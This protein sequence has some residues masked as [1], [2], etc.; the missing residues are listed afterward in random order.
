MINKTLLPLSWLYGMGVWVRNKLFDWEILPVEKFDVPV[1]SIGNLA[2]GGTGKT[3]H[4]EYLIRMLSPK[5]GVAVLSRGYKRKTR[6]FVLADG[7]AD[8]RSI[9]DEPYQIYRKFPEIIVAVDSN[10]RRGIRNL[11]YATKSPKPD[12]ILLDDA[13]QH[14]Y[15]KPSFSI[16]LSDSRRPFY[17]DCLLPAGRLREPAKNVKRADLI[18]F[19]KYNNKLRITNYELRNYQFPIINSQLAYRSLLPVFPKEN[20]TQKESMER[21][22]EASYSVLLLAGLASP[23]DLIRYIEKYTSGLQTMIYPD[24]HDFSRKDILKITE[25]FNRIQNTNKLIIT[26][27]KDAV[28]LI[29]NPHIPEEIKDLIYYIPIAVVFEPEQE[30]LFAQIIEN[31][32]KH[33]I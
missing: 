32:V 5:Y 4:T 26:S 19:T 22:R 23:E 33:F 31:H 16:L 7:H 13:F 3:P 10:R 15:V 20:S 12:V 8:N 6:G 27:E 2:I 29:H 21:L 11:L 28:R 9:G 25:N 14:R 24:H 1:I 17:E 18:I 30:K